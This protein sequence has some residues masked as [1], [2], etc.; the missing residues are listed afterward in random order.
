M[1]LCNLFETAIGDLYNIAA[2]HND[3]G[4][5]GRPACIRLRAGQ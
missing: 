5:S 1:N 3:G 2:G 4:I